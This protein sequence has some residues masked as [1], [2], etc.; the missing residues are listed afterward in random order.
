MYGELDNLRTI[1]KSQ[2]PAHL[3]QTQNMNHCTDH[4]VTIFIWIQEAPR[5]NPG[6]NTGRPRLFSCF[7]S[8]APGKC[9]YI[10]S[11]RPRPLASKEFPIHQ[12]VDRPTT[13]PHITE[14]TTEHNS[15]TRKQVVKYFE[16]KNCI[17][18]K[19]PPI[20]HPLPTTT[21]SAV[22]E[23]QVIKS[24]TIVHQPPS[25]VP[26][27]L[28]SFHASPHHTGLTKLITLYL[29]T[30]PPCIKTEHFN[31]SATT[32][33]LQHVCQLINNLQVNHEAYAFPDEATV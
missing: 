26:Q 18:W 32:F 15:Y 6:R 20:T 9:P 17:S 13:R 29:N 27:K 7:S 11:I 5:S 33:N 4:A 28:Y 21:T 31:A 2:Q 30:A 22:P 12:S 1:T 14:F 10:T 23:C 16:L 3:N 24:N 8:V 25:Q 19:L